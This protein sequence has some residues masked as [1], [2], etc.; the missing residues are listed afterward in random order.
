MLLVV[1][2]GQYFWQDS[3]WLL[4]SSLILHLV[5]VRLTV[6]IA[7]TNMILYSYAKFWASS[8]SVW[9]F[10]KGKKR[11]PF[12]LIFLLEACTCQL[13][14]MCS[15]LLKLFLFLYWISIILE[16][17]RRW[18]P[19]YFCW[20]LSVFTSMRIVLSFRI[21]IIGKLMWYLLLFIIK[22]PMHAQYF[23]TVHLVFFTV[24][25]L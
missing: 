8:A 20:S 9:F 19:L 2:Y 6:V 5:V 25:S 23:G 21:H 11:P 1:N 18:E 7:L 4:V 10:L 16:M 17:F 12:P 22:V 13:I 3:Q 14:L 24:R 15:L